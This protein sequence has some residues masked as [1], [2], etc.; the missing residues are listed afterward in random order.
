MR[1][2]L[3]VIIL[4]AVVVVPGTAQNTTTT[5]LEAA[6]HFPADTELFAVVQTDSEH[7]GQLDTIF[8]QLTSDL[9]DDVV[10]PLTLREALSRVLLPNF[11][12][13]LMNA[14]S[15]WIGDYIAVG[16]T[17]IDYLLDTDLENDSEAR[18][19]V[20]MDVRNQTL[21]LTSLALTGLLRDTEVQTMDDGTMIYTDEAANRVLAINDKLLWVTI[22]S[23]DLQFNYAQV[24]ADQPQYA[25]TV[26]EL[27]ADA[28]TGII[29]QSASTLLRDIVTDP[30]VQE[31]FAAL[32][33]DIN[34]LGDIA[35]GFKIAD[36]RS[37]ILDVV[38][39]RTTADLPASQPLDPD[40]V[41][42][43]PA[44]GSFVLQLTDLNTLVNTASGL[45]AS[46][47]ASETTQTIYDQFE[48][49]TRLL[50]GL[51]LRQDIL[52]WTRGDY[53]VVIELDPLAEDLPLEIGALF[54]ITDRERAEILVASLGTAIVD[55]LPDTVT[56]SEDVLVIDTSSNPIRMDVL[57]FDIETETGNVVMVL[58]VTDEL[59]LLATYD[60]AVEILAEGPRLN[61]AA[62]YQEAD[63]YRLPESYLMVFVNQ[64]GPTKLLVL[65]SALIEP[66][67][68]LVFQTD[69]PISLTRF[70]DVPVSDTFSSSTVSIAASPENSVL[71]RLVVTLQAKRSADAQ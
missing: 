60:M 21:A 10:P 4:L 47:S 34:T 29:Y 45:I 52:D 49:L 20:V 51:D 63:R 9:P 6:R 7:L 14:V 2:I 62:S 69:I 26:S 8:Y 42:N 66:L 39:L 3:L 65:G 23:T 32:G 35:I 43:L 36:E 56:V 38:Q 71:L 13:N 17:G 1:R 53:G 61:E 11:E 15:L 58:G 48:R 16:L 24:L 70:T 25:D 67:W 64:D 12:G 22:G 37:L 27:P 31:I 19:Q 40:F 5:L 44:D 59:L 18:V 46:I 50:L 30:G 54:E 57:K 33:L 68:N 55:L 28:Y 41:A